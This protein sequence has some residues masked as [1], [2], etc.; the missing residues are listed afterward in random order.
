LNGRNIE[1]WNCA[2]TKNLVCSTYGAHPNP[3]T[4]R[5]KMQIRP[6]GQTQTTQAVN[7][8]TEN[9]TS[10]TQND[11]A[12]APVDQLEISVEAQAMSGLDS[13]SGIRADRV[14]ELRAEIASGEFETAER[15]DRAVSRMLDAIA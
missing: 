3:E 13:S 8:Q 11:V 15:L 4:G 5:I 12:S 7:L 9:T 10:A 14:A 1:K 6:T 2:E